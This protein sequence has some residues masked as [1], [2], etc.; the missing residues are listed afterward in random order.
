MVRL[1]GTPRAV[2][3]GLLRTG[4]YDFDEGRLAHGAVVAKRAAEVAHSSNV[5]SLEV[6][7]EALV[8]DFLRELG[9]VRGAL[10]ACDRA[11]AACRAAGGK[12]PPRLRGEV[13]RSRGILLRRVGRVGEA[14][15]AHVDAIAIFKRSGARRGEARVKNSLAYSMFVQGHYEDAIALALESFQIDLSIGGR[16]QIA[17]TLTTIGHTYFRLGDVCRAL[18]YLRRAREAH[19]RYGDQDGWA[20]TL[21]VSAM[22]AT[23][24]GDV[25][26]AESH[27]R[28]AGA[29]IAA[30]ENAYDRV[31]E[32]VV[33]ALLARASARSQEAVEHALGARRSA[34]G[35]ALV[36]FH[37]YAMAIEAAA[38][39]DLGE[40]HAATFLAT[41]ALGA[42]ENLQGCEYELEI[43]TL[44][45]DALERAGSPNA[46]DAREQTLEHTRR[47]ISTVRD[48]RLRSLFPRRPLNAALLRVAPLPDVGLTPIA[49]SPRTPTTGGPG[50]LEGA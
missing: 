21:L 47:L 3:L 1:V 11:L 38:R 2:C 50:A 39:A 29:L 17:K 48:A 27:V 12:V 7:A 49:P 36:A 16:F 19:D 18:A 43:R 15:D 46:S 42:V 5:A 10:A 34:E 4:R 45:T 26:A 23:E 24:M 30:T 41:T 31:Y 14:V 35:M 25:S 22:V 28:D 8:S 13:L 20:E 6:E 9:D 37:F 44:C 32:S 40:A 33:R